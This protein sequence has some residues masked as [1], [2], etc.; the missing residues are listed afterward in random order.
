MRVIPLDFNPKQLPILISKD[1]R[2]K[3]GGHNLFPV[4]PKN[5][6]LMY[7]SIPTVINPLTYLALAQ[8]YEEPPL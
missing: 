2:E 8:L 6:L 3:Q 5:V 4:L 7:P 1:T